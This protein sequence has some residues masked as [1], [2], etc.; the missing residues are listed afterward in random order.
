MVGANQVEVSVG[1][2]TS[3]EE[4][5]A[6]HISSG[7]YGETKSPAPTSQVPCPSAP[8]VDFDVSDPI[9]AISALLGQ[10]NLVKQSR[11]NLKHGS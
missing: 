10:V 4:K 1:P 8:H 3:H 7:Q 9:S 11:S 6:C 2:A 5:L